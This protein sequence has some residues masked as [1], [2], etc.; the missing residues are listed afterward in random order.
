MAN[1]LQGKRIAFLA[2]DGVEQVE[3][4]EPWE[5]VEAA[6]AEPVLLSLEP[7]EIQASTTSTRGT[8]SRSTRRSQR[9]IRPTSTASSCRAASPI[10]TS[11]AAT[12]TRSGSSGASSSRGCPSA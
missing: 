8:P 11:C 1:E 7:G 4:T 6:G 12:R 2:A 9:P 5:A 10:P 3:L